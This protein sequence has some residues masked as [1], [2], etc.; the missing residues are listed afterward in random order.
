MQ[1]TPTAEPL[2]FSGAEDGRVLFLLPRD[3]T[4]PPAVISLADSWA[5]YPRG[6][7]IFLGRPIPAGDEAAFAHAAWTYFADPSL[8]AVRVAWFADPTAATAGCTIALY[9][10]DANNWATSRSTVFDLHNLSL[11]LGI[12]AVATF[13]AAAEAI[14]F[15]QGDPTTSYLT[16]ANGSVTL[17][18]LI[19]G[20]LRIPLSGPHAGCLCFPA[21]LAQTDGVPD[22]VHLDIGL[23]QFYADAD[24]MA[25]ADAF[26]MESQRYPVFATEQSTLQLYASIDPLALLDPARTGFVFHASDVGLEGNAAAEIPSHYRSTLGEQVTLVPRDSGTAVT[27]CAKLVFAERPQA[28]PAEAVPPLYLVPMGDFGIAG[29]GD[30]LCGLSGVEYVQTAAD[31]ALLSFFPGAP[32]FAAGFLPGKSAG[33]TTLVPDTAP[34]TSFASITNRRAPPSYY[35][36]PDQSV[37]FNYAAQQASGVTTLPSLAAVP[38]LAGTLP[39]TPSS[40]LTYPLL[41]YAGVDRSKSSVFAQLES[42]VVSPVRRVRLEAAP[43]KPVSPAP[44]PASKY[45]TTPQGLLITYVPGKPSWDEVVLGRM[46]NGARLIFSNVQGDLLTA[47]QSN[48]LFLVITD[49][50]ALQDTLLP[51]NAVVSIGTDPKELWNFDLTPSGWASFGTIFI[52]KFH[53]RAIAELAG[54]PDVWTSASKFNSD[55]TGTAK[56]LQGIIEQA[57]N[58]NDTDFDTFN[59]A[60]SDPAWNGIL[61]LNARAPLDELPSQLAGLAAG[62]DP[63]AFYAHHVAIHA[64]KILVPQTP[65]D[66]SITDSSIFGL[67]HYE[68]PAPLQRATGADYQF[69]VEL[70]KVLFINS[71][72]AGFSSLI[73][74][75]INRLFGDAAELVDNPGNVVQMYGVYQKREVNGTI[76]ELYLFQTLTG[77]A[78]EYALTSQVFNAVL[79]TDGQFVTVSDP[80]ATLTVS[81]F[82]LAGQLDFTALEDF[83]AF[84]FGRDADSTTATG[85]SFQNLVISMSSD[86]SQPEI[87]PQ[88]SFDASALTFDPAASTARDGSFY[89]HFPLALTGLTQGKSGSAP[90]DLGFMSVQTPLA[91]STLEFP[92]YSL[93]FNLDLGSQGGLAAQSGFVA[94]LTLAW[95]PATGS[96]YSV[97]IGLRLP[98][99]SG[100]KKVIS[101][102]GIFE[103]TFRNIAIIASAETA[104]YVLILYGIAF[105]FLSFSFPPTGQ[106][107]FV[108][109]GDPGEGGA[110]KNLGW[111]AAYAKGEQ[112]QGGTTSTPP[113]L[114]APAGD[115]R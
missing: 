31:D 56:T 50:A 48:Q 55:A 115:V 16:A 37:L 46:S 20:A 39:D 11:V 97:F 43:P 108:L 21:L 32:A 100:S 102:Q 23:R 40:A 34:T 76:E 51:E 85:L 36:Q 107:N 109:F 77:L 1:F 74:L 89:R 90:T 8:H 69:Q 61:V 45:S 79:I 35:A 10:P 103:I 65:S 99:S 63:R 95:S 6:V 54:Q 73:E 58:S 9:Q 80:D 22:L 47:L 15:A 41:P 98:G 88:F 5:S 104:G 72:V 57:A 14:E 83:D 4:D 87:I 2:L 24:N 110:G 106:V 67:I 93:D 7:Y 82:V 52:L 30:V 84:S 68:A 114:P 105:E 53:N 25:T 3:T 59:A 92:W 38:V 75:Q 70:L 112:K 94:A 91:Q 19:N 78:A 44:T 113:Q 42:Q 27:S 12:N 101:I 33:A 71:A 60:V 62:I 17:R 64:S 26:Y 29:V 86:N 49:P 18:N 28:S 81:Q 13:D 111:Y 96:S 66:L